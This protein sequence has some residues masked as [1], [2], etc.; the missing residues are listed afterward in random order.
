[1]R[2]EYPHLTHV[3]PTWTSHWTLH[4]IT[5]MLPRLRIAALNRYD[6]RKDTHKSSISVKFCVIH[7]TES[8]PQICVVLIGPCGVNIVDS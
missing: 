8:N 5:D 3:S 2:T 6:F 7:V 4:F 1:M